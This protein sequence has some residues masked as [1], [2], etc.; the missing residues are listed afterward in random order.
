MEMRTCP[1]CGSPVGQADRFCGHCRYPLLRMKDKKGFREGIREALPAAVGSV[2]LGILTM[3]LFLLLG[4]SILAHYVGE[5]VNR[6]MRAILGILLPYIASVMVAGAGIDLVLSA[7]CVNS[8]LGRILCTLGAAAAFCLS[9][10]VLQIF[11]P[12]LL[13]GAGAVSPEIITYS[14]MI[15]RGILPA[16]PLLHGAL[17]CCAD[18]CGLRGTVIRQAGFSVV[19]LV[20]ALIIAIL[21]TVL[22][23]LGANSAGIAGMGAAAVVLLAAVILRSVT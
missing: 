15:G 21:M 8:K 2:V 18:G 12:A 3:V 16:V 22:F 23:G 9:G 7:V 17:F 1:N 19:F 20:L 13:R 14:L 11:F 6:A 10:I 4:G 5:E